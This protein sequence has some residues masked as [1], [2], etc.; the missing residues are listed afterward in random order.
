MEN[1]VFGGLDDLSRPLIRNK[2]RHRSFLLALVPPLNVKPFSCTLLEMAFA[3]WSKSSTLICILGG[4]FITFVG[5][6][7]LLSYLGDEK[8]VVSFSFSFLSGVVGMFSFAE[9][10]LCFLF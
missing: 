5:P 9:G 6:P 7:L 10:D 3:R 8:R 4:A 1:H 2:D